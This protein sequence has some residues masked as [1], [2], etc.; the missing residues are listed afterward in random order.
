MDGQQASTR[1]GIGILVLFLLGSTVALSP[2]RAAN[3]DMWLAALAAFALAVPVALLYGRLTRLYPDKTLYDLMLGLLGPV[4]GRAAILAIVLFSFHLGALVIR[5]FTEYITIVTLR[6]QPQYL[7][8]IPIG[9]CAVWFVRSGRMTLGRWSM[10]VLPAVLASLAI[11][12]LLSQNLWDPGN[13]TPMLY[14][15]LAPVMSGAF[16]ILGFP[17]LEAVLAVCLI[18][19]MAARSSPYKTYLAGFAIG[20][21]VLA[22]IFARNTMVLS[23]EQVNKF[24]FPSQSV[25]KLVSIGDFIQGIETVVV[26]IY[27]FGGITK[28]AV[29]LYAATEGAAKLL[30]QGFQ[31]L[32]APVGLMM[33]T[34]SLFVAKDVADM[35]DWVD[36]YYIFYVLPFGLGIPALLW[37]LAEIRHKRDCRVQTNVPGNTGP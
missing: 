16:D 12:S 23:Y 20:A 33:I 11:T 15:G 3:R 24:Y 8:A 6:Y 5:D 4:L 34:F 25:I 29:C 19:P 13:L 18:T 2:G 21:V 37:V 30:G 7:F 1:Q 9:L 32:A 31:S 26:F 36:K 22:A 28:I 14:D 17:F 10:I 27:L 35:F